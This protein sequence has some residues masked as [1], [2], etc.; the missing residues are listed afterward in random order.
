MCH[1]HGIIKLA[2]VYLPTAH[3][4]TSPQSTLPFSYVL[5]SDKPL[6]QHRA[7]E[8]LKKSV[9]PKSTTVY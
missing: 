7:P 2:A 4:G 8:D 1:Q 5:A 3:L 9:W 6:D